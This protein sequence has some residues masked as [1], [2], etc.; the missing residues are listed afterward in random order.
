MAI[1]IHGRGR[2]IGVTGRYQFNECIGAELTERSLT[3]LHL[4]TLLLG[5]LSEPNRPPSFNFKLDR[6]TERGASFGAQLCAHG[7]RAVVLGNEHKLSML[8]RPNFVI[9]ISTRCALDCDNKLLQLWRSC[10]TRHFDEICFSLRRNNPAH[11]A[12][13]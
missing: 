1:A 9:F 12:H 2:Q 6:P 4:V 8:V 5:H 7:D 10:V 3:S 13:P 11:S